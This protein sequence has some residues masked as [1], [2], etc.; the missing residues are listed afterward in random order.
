MSIGRHRFNDIIMARP[1]LMVAL[2]LFHCHLDNETL[3]LVIQMVQLA[4]LDY[5]HPLL[6]TCC[7]ETSV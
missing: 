6:V 5:V 7:V 3:A 4:A 2:Y 1:H